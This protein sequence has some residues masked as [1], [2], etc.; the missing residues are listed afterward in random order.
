MPSRSQ[1]DGITGAVKKAT[2]F[3]LW[4]I[5]LPIVACLVAIGPVAL[6]FPAYFP[7][8]FYVYVFHPLLSYPLTF[9]ASLLVCVLGGYVLSRWPTKQL[10]YAVVPGA[11]MGLTMAWVTPQACGFDPFFFGTFVESVL[12]L[13]A[14]VLTARVRDY[15]ALTCGVLALYY[16]VAVGLP[17]HA[18]LCHN[19]YSPD[20]GLIAVSGRGGAWLTVLAAMA[21]GWLSA[22]IGTRMYRLFPSARKKPVY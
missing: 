22:W 14:A 16:G 8:C 17:L 19:D 13:G 18:A 9:G 21:L 3:I 10:R 1:L 15:D 4:V 20:A 2:K 7:F 11:V 5:V 12:F 6:V